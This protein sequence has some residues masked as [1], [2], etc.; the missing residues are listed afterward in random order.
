MYLLIVRAV[1][2]LERQENH[3]TLGRGPGF[4]MARI[5][6]SSGGLSG[7]RAD[8]GT[9]LKG[10]GTP[11]LADRCPPRLCEDCLS[12]SLG[13]SS[14]G[15]VLPGLPLPLPRPAVDFKRDMEGVKMGLGEEGG[16]T[17]SSLMGARSMAAS[18]SPKVSTHGSD[19]NLHKS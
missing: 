5:L 6:I 10:W 11:A 9:V 17:G 1:K 15:F 8:G 4:E 7:V 14:L 12:V 16:E 19:I 13:G 18:S 2:V 3:W